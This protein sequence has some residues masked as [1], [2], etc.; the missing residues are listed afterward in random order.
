MVSPKFSSPGSKIYGSGENAISNGLWKVTKKPPSK[1]N[2][3]DFIK[4]NSNFSLVAKN[5]DLTTPLP[6]SPLKAHLSGIRES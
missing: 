5:Q 1:M 4:S 3:A 2:Q 6:S